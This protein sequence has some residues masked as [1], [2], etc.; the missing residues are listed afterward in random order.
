MATLESVVGHKLKD[1]TECYVCKETMTDP[2]ILPCLHIFCVECLQWAINAG[3]EDS[4]DALLC[5]ICW[6]N[7]SDP[8]FISFFGLKSNLYMKRLIKIK[9]LMDPCESFWGSCFE[10]TS[11]D[12]EMYCREC[13][14]KLCAGCCANHTMKKTFRKHEL[15]TIRM[16]E[17][18]SQ[19]LQE[20]VVSCCDVHEEQIK[21][22][23]TDCSEA[24]CLVCFKQSHQNH[25]LSDL[26][27][28]ANN[29]RGQIRDKLT[30]QSENEAGVMKK[31]HRLDQDKIV[32][33]RKVE[34]LKSS[35]NEAREDMVRLV[36]EQAD[37]LLEKIDIIRKKR[38]NDFEAEKETYSRYQT[39]LESFRDCCIN[40]ITMGSSSDVCWARD[41]IIKRI[42]EL[43]EEYVSLN[44]RE[45]SPLSVYFKKSEIKE[46]IV[47]Q[48][49]GEISIYLT[50][51]LLLRFCY[52]KNSLPEKSF[53]F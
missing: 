44:E 41:D 51:R 6:R 30:S 36:D 20:I 12:D 4:S 23:C 26:N 42:K 29:F 27:S 35:V 33:L 43:D 46:N 40:M 8:Q 28:V 17:T 11:P 24:N 38:L 39:T 7:F 1:I 34:Y 32:F 5:P 25:R 10:F 13:D 18:T 3:G 37:L 22:Y 31:K 53:L 16:E 9:E 19:S 21:L 50:Y 52:G 2:Q 45:L 47:G 48:I 49:K 15:F 14:T